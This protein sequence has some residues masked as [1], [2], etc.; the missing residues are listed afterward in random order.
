MNTK[1][2]DELYEKAKKVMPG[3]VNSPVRAFK[4]V[5]RN[6]VFIERAY[7]DRIIDVD[8]NEY[9]DF[10]CSWGPGILG[11]AYPDVVEAVKKAAE[12]GLTYGAPTNRETLLIEHIQDAFPFVDKMRLVSSG[13]EAV[14]SAVRAVRGFTRRDKIIKFDGCYHGHSDSVLFSSG[15][16]LATFSTPDSAGIPKKV[17]ED[18]L[19]ATFNDIDSVRKLYESY[20]QDI[21]A[22][23][24]EPAMA[25]RG[26]TAP[27]PGFLNELRNLT[28][29][30]ESLLIFDEVITGFRLSYGGASEYY[31]V[32]PDLVTLGKIVGGGM[33]LA[34][35]GGRA[36]IMAC[37]SPD[38]AVYQAGTLSGNPL[39][40]AAGLETLKQLKKDKD[41]YGRLAEKA[42][43]LETALK[44]LNGI[45]I[46]RAGSLLS[47]SFGNEDAD[48]Y[49]EFFN[50]LLER[51]IYIAPSQYEALFLSDAHTEEDIDKT[52]N[53]IQ[54]FT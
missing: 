45:N 42:D 2:S 1:L 38:G 51:G 26:V 41:I 54:S 24:V 15:S 36:D 4:S 31:G 53:V 32:T 47:I 7:K 6:P 21:A 23:I 33:P 17:S 11:H 19:V 30:Y 29:E 20:G 8:G 10:V 14:M 49:A 44:K 25:N 28:K 40:T 37:I 18:T 16:G 35:Y 48:R 50:Y 9:I 39:A 13:T 46:S 5:K 3:G 43:K 34:A 52:I 27:N 22:V 12:N